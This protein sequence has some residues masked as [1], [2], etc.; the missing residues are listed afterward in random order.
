[1]DQVSGSGAIGRP[2]VVVSVGTSVDGRVTLRRDPDGMLWLRY[3][4]I[5]DATPTPTA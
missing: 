5:R 1:M 2:R 4:V 3:E